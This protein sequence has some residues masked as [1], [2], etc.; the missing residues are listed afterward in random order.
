MDFRV[1]IERLG[2]VDATNQTSMVQLTMVFYW[3]D[4]RMVGW[5]DP[6]LLPNELWGPTLYLENGIDVAGS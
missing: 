6:S 3:N 1:N 2:E 4:S 5:S